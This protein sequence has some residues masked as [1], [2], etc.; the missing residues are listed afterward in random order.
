MINLD[1]YLKNLT[2]KDEAK[3][4]EVASY[5]V[6]NSDIELFNL[7]VAN[8]DFLFDFVRN[9]VNKRIEKAVNKSNF[10][11]LISFFDVYS[12]YY[13]DLFTL[14]LAKHADEDLTDKMFDL[15]DRGSIAQ[16]TY[17]AKYFLYI[18]DTV[19]IELLAKY[20]FFDDEALAYNAAEALGQMQDDVSFDIAL[21]NL[22]SADDFEKLKAVKFFVAYGRNYPFSEIFEALKTSK[23]PENIA[24]Q[25]PYMVSLC[26]LLSSNDKENALCV[27]D[28]ILSGLGE[29]L[30]LSE[31]F[32]FELY[33]ALEIL[34][35]FN[36]I[37]NDLA[38]EISEILLKALAK[39]K[40]FCEN[41]EYIFDEDKDTK[42][43]IS[44][45][46]K[47]LQA[48]NQDFW[49]NQKHFVIRELKSTNDRILTVLPIISEFALKDAVEGLKSLL[50]QD[51]EIVICDV[52]TCLKNLNKLDDIDVQK[53]ADN[54][55]NP[56]IKAYIETLKA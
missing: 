16:K 36:K 11:N 30:P 41:Q 42:Y 53:I 52:L 10:M 28:N 31:I 2:G 45:I 19:S 40:L 1:L 3:A 25:I 17:A 22:S 14:I 47:L 18:P 50:N 21:S 55:E 8:S 56:N 6:D 35:E 4:Q 46:F 33:D 27:L 49:N 51:N 7:L 23:M 20:A 34:I 48:Q 32:Q 29:I 15:L 54:V 5:M 43:E 13:D 44:A 26:E 24:G 39:F 12:S 38:G 9:N 37:D